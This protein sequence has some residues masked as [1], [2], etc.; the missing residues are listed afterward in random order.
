MANT[1]TG[2]LDTSQLDYQ[3]LKQNL[4]TFLSQ[5]DEFKDYD[6]EGSNLTVLLDLLTYN[7]YQNALY[8]NMVGSEMF[9]DTAILRQSIVSRAKELNY[10]PRSMVSASAYLDLTLSGN[11]LPTVVTIPA[12]FTVTGKS[13]NGQSFSFLSGEAINISAANNWSGYQIPFYEG[14]L[15]TETFV[16]N[17][18]VRYT[19]SSANVDV[20]SIKVNVQSSN[21]NSANSNWVKATTLFGYNGESNVFFVQ[22]YA[23]YNYE[24][25]FGTGV[26]GANVRDGNIVRISYRQTNGPLANG[27]KTFTVN[28][29]LPNVGSITATLSNNNVQATGG[30]I[31]ESNNEIQFNAPKYFA[32]QERAV[33]EGDY[34]TLLKA[35]FPQ[36]KAVTAYG[37]EKVS[38]PQYGKVVISA[39]P[40]NGTVLPNTLKNQI[41]NF[42]QDKAGLTITPIYRDPDFYYAA[43]TG[44]TYYN[45][46]STPKSETDIESQ[47]IA[48]ITNFANTALQGFAK[49]LR[50]SKLSAAIDDADESVINSDVK[51]LMIKKINPLLEV[52]SSY[53]WSFGNQIYTDSPTLYAYPPG[54]QPAITSSAFSYTKGGTSY[55]SFIQDDGLGNLYIYTID[56][57]G[58]KV[59]L[60]NTVGSINY[61][62]GQ[63]TINNLIVNALPI[64]ASTLN[65]YARLITNDIAT[66]ANQVLIIDP[67]DVTITAIG[68]RI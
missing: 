47:T 20:T 19:L 48:A 65:I 10:T 22:G 63:V 64:G 32:T 2:F 49:N 61:A 55:S 23:D 50:F 40:I 30:A 66:S 14:K 6:F 3:T 37:G 31:A 34:E 60:N 26:V 12:N 57:Q 68:E 51:V 59:V 45:I 44:Q 53:V 33:T 13:S 8:L 41:I 15:V 17:S 62:T 35:E 24:V 28:T 29:A 38:P 16:A 42:L 25:K 67:M 9:L 56:S 39:K 21:T 18:S 11:N 27:I 52:S 46:N 4:K 5:S 36:L 43:V 54:R 7:T 1:N 58:N